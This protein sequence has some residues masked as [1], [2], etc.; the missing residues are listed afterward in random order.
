MAFTMHSHSGQFCP[1]HAKDQLEDIILHAIKI[2]YKTIGLTEHMPRTA[3]SDLYPEELLPSPEESLAALAPRHEA[4]L[5]EAARLQAKYAA[6]IRVLIGFEADWIR[7]AEYGPLIRS[8]AANP[9]VDYFVGSL[10]HARGIPIDFDAAMYAQAVAACGGTEEGLWE[11]Y[12]DEQLAMLQEVR[13]RVVGHF[14][15]PRLFSA[16]VG[17]PSSGGGG[18][19]DGADG[20]GDGDRDGETKIKRLTEWRRVWE[21]VVRNLEFV[22]AY[23]GWLECNTS[24]LRKGLAEAYPSREIAQEWVRMGGRFTF[25]DDSHGIAQVATNYHRGLDYLEG[26]GVREL[27]TL[28][29]R[30]GTGS[31]GA[32]TE[33]VKRSVTIDEFRAS[34]R[35]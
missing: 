12:L 28:E 11:V 34:L 26:L 5:A 8:L 10:H 7:A 23:G 29:R 25:S 19:G 13:P 27:W 22:R 15:L 32:K 14:D 4:Y 31:E 16:S 35:L 24:G 30:P 3:L 2:G 9:A 17:R 1:G 21:R 18:G 33:V 20:D 6:Q